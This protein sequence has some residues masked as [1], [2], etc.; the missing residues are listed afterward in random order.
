VFTLTDDAELLAIARSS[1]KVRWLK[2]LM[3]YEN[4]EK[5]KNPVFWVGPVLAGNRLWIANS[6]GELAFADPSSGEMT[7]FA[8]LGAP[9]SLAPVVAGQTLYV[10]DDSGR[11]TAFR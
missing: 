8:E 6:R 3:R 1:G 11:I 10:L 4:E 2:Q 7:Q 5:R 9:V